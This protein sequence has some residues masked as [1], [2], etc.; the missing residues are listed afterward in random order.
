MRKRRTYIHKGKIRFKRRKPRKEKKRFKKYLDN[1]W[2][3]RE[4]NLRKIHGDDWL[5]HVIIGG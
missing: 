4:I 3:Q 1:L 5:R 2:I